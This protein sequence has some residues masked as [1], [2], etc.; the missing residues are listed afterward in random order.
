MPK[1][2][3]LIPV[4]NVSEYLKICLDSVIN[5]TERDLE[6]ICVEDCSQDN[7]LEILREYANLDPRIRL[8]VHSE[9]KGLC[10]SRKDAV[11][12][13]KGD[14]IIFLDSDDYLSLDACQNL[15]YEIS[16]RK[17][18]F[19]QF[20]TELIP[21]ENVPHEMM[22]WIQNFMEP[23]AERI[24]SENL[25][26]ACFVEKK[27]NC[28][29]VNKIWATKCC[30][31]AYREI[32]DGHYI[33]GED[34]YAMF[35]L[36]YFA[37]SYDGTSD[38]YY[39]YRVG[40]G[41]TGGKELDLERFQNRCKGALI[42]ENIEEFLKKEQ[43]REQYSGEY[44]AFYNDILWDCVDCWHNKLNLKD[45]KAGYQMLLQYWGADNVIDA[46]SCRYFEEQSG[47][48]RRVNGEAEETVCIYY[49]YIG[50]TEMDEILGKYIEFQKDLGNTVLLMTDQDS[51]EQGESYLGYPLAHIYS[52]TDANWDQ[53]GIRCKEI[54]RF[55]LEEKVKEVYYLSPT[56][57]VARL[58]KLLV[59][60]VG[61]KFTLCMDEYTLDRL[62]RVQKE[63]ERQRDNLNAVKEQTTE[64]K[65]ASIWRKIFHSIFY[66]KDEIG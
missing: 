1:I 36:T 47:I 55:L 21:N 30:Q 42:T 18:D 49:R 23:S 53:Y 56:S 31:R 34:R 10:Q 57:H 45:Y 22:Q 11:L 65:K 46:I 33:S 64:P 38:K 61:K 19:L 8:L 66:R 50:Y 54:S 48:L 63:A 29:L 40:V 5:Q 32:K 12:T 58:D 4:Y 17:V 24:E 37:S 52:A 16:N 6:I 15:Y 43:K 35:L 41:V 9:N 3:I 26:H 20:G 62:N 7:S 28:N 14:F 44:V 59:E 13:A 2:S 39:H 27:F 51:P 25:V 60:S